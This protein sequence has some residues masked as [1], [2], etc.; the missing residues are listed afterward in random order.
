M[1]SSGSERK[2]YEL[3]APHTIRGRH[4]DWFGMPCSSSKY[5]EKA[6]RTAGQ[7]DAGVYGTG[8]QGAFRVIWVFLP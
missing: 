3:P 4:S 1:V 5:S 8:Q 7:D 2:R 6:G